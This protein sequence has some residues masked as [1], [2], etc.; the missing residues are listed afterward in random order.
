MVGA[1][2]DRDSP[3][4]ER[5]RRRVVEALT[6]EIV[7]LRSAD[8]ALEDLPPASTVSVT[9]SP[10]KGIP[11]TRELTDRIRARGHR[12]VPHLAARMVADRGEVDD[13]ARW[14][15]TEGIT[16]AFVVGGDAEQ[17]A[18]P[19]H[20]GATLLRDLLDADPGLRAVGVPGYP[21]GHPSVSGPVI[22]E[23][24]RAKQAIIAEAGIEG[25][26][27]TQ[28]CFDPERLI[29]WGTRE[30][31]GGLELPIH[32]GVAGVVE[33]SRLMTMGV[34]LGVGAS[35]RYLRKNRR[36]IGRL[37][38]SADYDPGSLLDPLAP[39]L[40]PLGIRALHCFTFNQVGRTAAW[41]AAALGGG[42]GSSRP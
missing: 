25:W 15:R 30:R 31:A 27:S 28:M 42:D 24:L 38:S 29:A 14:L 19:Y 9:C 20:D 18:G 12:V 39:Y 5:A 41:R 8:T 32:L 33:R 36:A 11:A 1:A 10:V 3:A 13:L 22:D 23:A 17:P 2:D 37:L 6:F 16:E 40:D 4:A 35:L 26:V 7:P 34:R 21:D